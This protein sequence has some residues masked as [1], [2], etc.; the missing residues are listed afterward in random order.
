MATRRLHPSPAS[1]IGT[2]LLQR[3]GLAALAL[4]AAVSLTTSCSDGG[5]SSTDGS[6]RGNPG[7][8][9]GD[10]LSDAQE[11]NGWEIAVDAAGVGGEGGP[12]R[13]MVTSDPRLAD[14]DG[15]GLSDGV[16]FRA[17]SNPRE[18]DTD[19]DG[20]SDADEWNRWGTSP[21]SADSDGD[22]RGP[23]GNLPPRAELLDGN[24]IAMLG[25]SPTL[26]DTDGD[27]RTDYQEFA[28]GTTSPLIA[29][30][31]EF[32]M[33]FA[34][35]LDVR[36]DIEYA[37][38]VGQ[39]SEYG[40]TFSTSRTNT[41]SS[42]SSMT[43]SASAT[44]SSQVQTRIGIMPPGGVSWTFG[45]ALGYAWEGSW[46]SSREESSTS[47]QEHSRYRTESR[48]RTEVAASGRIGSGV[49]LRNVGDSTFTLDNLT[50]AVLYAPEGVDNTYSVLATMRM[51]AGAVTLAPNEA[52]PVLEFV[53]SDVNADV[54]KRF[55]ARPDSL[56]I[57]PGA[58]GLL[59]SNGIDF[60]FLTE[61]T[62]SRTARIEIQ[63]G[64]GEF[65]VF[66]IATTVNRDENGNPT[67]LTLSKALEIVGLTPDDA[68]AGFLFSD[69]IGPDGEPTGERVLESIRGHRFT[70][71]ATRNAS[72]FWGVIGS[73]REHTTVADISSI[74][75][76][77]GDTIILAFSEDRDEDGL[78]R[79]EED[80][81]GTSDA[82]VDSDED[83]LSDWFEIHDGWEAG[84]PELAT[85]GYPR[86]VESDPR[87]SDTDGDGLEDGA[88]RDAGT[89]PMNPD[90]DSDGLVDSEDPYPLIPALI[91]HVKPGASGMGTSWSDAI[92]LDA[93]LDAATTR[94]GD[95]EPAND[96]SQIWVA[97][98]TYSPASSNETFSLV[99]NVGV[100]GGFEGVSEENKR[101]KRNADPLAGLCILEGDL[102]GD[103]P[104]S[105]PL[106]NLGDNV[107]FLVE[108]GPDVH[109]RLDGFS[110][111][112]ASQRT[113]TTSG[114]SS[115]EFRNVLVR[116]NAGTFLL[117]GQGSRRSLVEDCVFVDN[118]APAGESV[119]FVVETAVIRTTFAYNTGISLD[120]AD[121]TVER[122]TFEWNEETAARVHP[123]GPVPGRSRF[124]NCE[125]RGN[126]GQIVG[127]LLADEDSA[128]AI[129][130]V[131]YR[132]EGEIAGAALT[133]NHPVWFINCTIVENG[134][135]G[136]VDAQFVTTSGDRGRFV[137]QTNFP[138]TGGVRA[139]GP[140]WLDNCILF[141]NTRRMRFLAGQNR[142]ADVTDEVAQATTDVV[143]GLVSTEVENSAQDPYGFYGPQP[144]LQGRIRASLVGQLYVLS[145]PGVIGGD[146]T[147]A[148]S[149]SGDLRLSSNSPCIDT[150]NRLVDTDPWTPG[151]QAL[152]TTD[153]DGNA[154]VTDASGRGRPQVDMGAYEVQER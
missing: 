73:R 89:D 75:I 99:D 114:A 39:S 33:E 8:S 44:F 59:D 136:T 16:E 57:R 17:R 31:P 101:A 28:S 80:L 103:D 41:T 25:T 135:T 123:I 105:G 110:I 122:A 47:Q 126:T 23:D 87:T 91:L 5:G 141:D 77:A 76:V 1:A 36:L 26:D 37:E 148:N 12:L 66:R 68:E 96:I 32:E 142:F 145:G 63:Y 111:Q 72:A 102:G 67:G 46:T 34:G 83:G 49:I 124:L 144:N 43:H 85:L 3:W 70:P 140:V 152:P 7:D 38:S 146:P 151:L 71:G 92:G 86:R 58:F 62:A 104:P 64:G 88:E 143:P 121:C 109:G 82:A 147:L 132:N 106:T 22:A 115:G 56:S 45:V 128:V 6:Q 11:L 134:A 54:I 118:E 18:V 40:T 19:D 125:F 60:E 150:G 48:D 53:A 94:N 2:H 81:R 154:R 27:G 29:N 130:C 9:D 129:G 131:F 21:S 14:T 108:I 4:T 149:P 51:P 116:R 98:G 13:L 95:A 93:A 107:R 97:R 52:S 78:L 119:A 61:K 117:I 50:S 24:E 15:D 127:G 74:P 79:F 65:E 153:L 69:S 35:D 139:G 90:T 133:G 137:T 138:A 42:S 100:Y 10:G 20:L 120:V 113:V 55:L 84:S 30:V 112:G